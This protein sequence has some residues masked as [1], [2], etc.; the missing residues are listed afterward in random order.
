MLVVCE[1]W[2]GD[3]DRLLH[4]NPSSSDH[5][6]T[7]FS[8]WLGLLNRRSLRAQAICL[9]L[10]LNLASCPQLTPTPTDSSHLCPGYIFVWRPPASTVLPLIYTGAS[11]DWRLSWGQY[12][13]HSS[14]EKNVVLLN[15]NT[16]PYSARIMQEKILYFGWFALSHPPYLPTLA[17]SDFQ[18]CCSLQKVLN[19]NKSFLDDQVKTFEENFLSLKLLNFTREKLTSYLIKGSKRWF[20]IMANILL[21]KI[22]SLLNYL[23][24]NYILLIQ[25]LYIW[26]S[27]SLSLSLFFL[28]LSPLHIYIYKYIQKRK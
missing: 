4:I 16:R 27:L 3:R 21:I 10:V 6:S 5:S 12:V 9:P 13:T 1:R 24:I 2:A 23:W 8:S 26:L 7:S 15:D 14:I 18:L 19:D 11:L 28:S 25:K 17:S 20:K 22:N